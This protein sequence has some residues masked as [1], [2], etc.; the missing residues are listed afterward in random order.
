MGS[1]TGVREEDSMTVMGLRQAQ[2]W[3]AEKAWALAPDL[4]TLGL[5]PQRVS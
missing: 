1:Q 4:S 2:H 5:P 3:R